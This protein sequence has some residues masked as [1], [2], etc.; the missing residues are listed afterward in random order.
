MTTNSNLKVGVIGAGTVG[1]MHIKYWQKVTGITIQALA[2]L[3]PELSRLVCQNFSIP[4]YYS[5]HHELLKCTDVDAVVVV[6]HRNHTAAVVYDCLRAKKNVFSEKP[7]AKTLDQAKTLVDLANEKKVKYRIGFQRRHDEGVQL[8]RQKMDELRDSRELGE[9]VSVNSW[10]FT[11]KDRIL[12]APE[13]VLTSEERPAGIKPW[14]Q[15]PEWLPPALSHN[16]DR[17]V[18][19]FSHDIN[20]LRYFF[21]N[22]VGVKQASLNELYRQNFV[23]D[24][25]K[26]EAIFQGS[27]NELKPWELRGEWD[28]GMEIHFEKG[29]LSLKLSPPLMHD[30]CSKVELKD[31]NGATKILHDGIPRAPTFQVQAAAFLVEVFCNQDPIRADAL[32]ASSTSTEDLC[33]IEEIWKKHLN[34]SS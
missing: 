17:F 26:F 13:Y 11:G 18:N 31:K 21:G 3:R 14:P 28:E 6:T 23:L 12:N 15:T 1:Q 29:I 24:F 8:A 32:S 19:V 10:D 25:G 34:I 7:M 22:M 9:L 30:S 2:E 16:Y 4:Q 33:I 27:F 20:L 5:S